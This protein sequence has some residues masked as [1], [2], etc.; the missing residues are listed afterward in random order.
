MIIPQITTIAKFIAKIHEGYKSIIEVILPVVQR[1]LVDPS[2]EVSEA[3]AMSLAN[4]SEILNTDDRGNYILTIVLSN[5][6]LIVMLIELA[7]DDENADNRIAAIQL[8]NKLAGK[9][10]KELCE[11]FVALEMMSMADDSEQKVRKT[12]IQ[13]F[14]KVCETVSTEFFVKK[15]LPVYQKYR[16]AY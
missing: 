8:L 11:N 1:L 15:L 12:T 2:A 14:V 13:S 16:D 10:G 7:H 5:A 6:L 4:I 3:A 9:F